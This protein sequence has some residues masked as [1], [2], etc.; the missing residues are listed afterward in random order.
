MKI[1]LP[2]IGYT[3]RVHKRN[4]SQNLA[5]WCEF[6]NTHGCD[7]FIDTPVKSVDVGLLAHEVTHILQHICKVRHIDFS[8]ETEHMG[9]I[10]NYIINT[11]LGIEYDV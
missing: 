11:I 4:K 3:I 7:M 8:E 10:M 2:H 6:S 5:A 1:V 9:Y